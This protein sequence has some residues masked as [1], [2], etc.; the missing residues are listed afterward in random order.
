MASAHNAT[1]GGGKS[2][3]Y[4]TVKKWEKELNCQLEYDVING[5]VHQMI[6][7]D[8]KRWELRINKMAKFSLAWIRPGTKTVEKDSLVKHLSSE[9]HKTAKNLSR[10]SELGAE[11]YM[12]RVIENTPIGR[13]LKKMHE[14][15]KKSLEIKFNT[16]YYLAKKERPYSDYNDLLTLQIKNNIQGIKSH[17]NND[18]TAATFT[19]YI[20]KVMKESLTADL[21]KSRYYACLNDGS[22]D[23]AVIEQEMVYVLF[24]H[25]GTPMVKYLSIESVKSADAEGVKESIEDAFNRIG[26]TRFSSRLTGLNADGASVN[27][28]I[29]RGLGAI[30]KKTAPWLEVIHCFNHRVELAIKDAFDHTEF[31]KIDEMLLKLHYLYKKSPKRLRE[32]QIFS[33][34]M[35]RAVPRPSKA[36][37]TRWIDHKFKAMET[38]LENYGVFMAHIESLSHTDSQVLKRAELEGF[39]KKWQHASYPVHMAIYLDV[40]SPIRRLSLAFQQEKHDPVKAVRRIQDF[41]WTMAKLKLL[42]DNSLESDN[43]K[44]TH[45]N[46][47]RSQIEVKEDGKRYYQNVKLK[48]FNST[49]KAVPGYY[50]DC[51]IRITDS[52][53]GRF[54]NLTES[55]VFK[56]LTSLLDV[57]IW[58][59]ENLT[60]FGD[61][62]INELLQHFRLVLTENGCDIYEA[63]NEWDVLKNTAYQIQINNPKASYLDT[64]KKLFC[65][66]GLRKECENI[67]HLIEILLITP[68]TNAKVERVFSRMARVKTDWRNRLSRDR[69]DNLM[70]IGEEG[71]SLSEY[72]PTE[73]ISSW[74]NAKVRRLTSSSHKYPE[75]RKKSNTKEIIDIT[76][77]TM[78]DLENDYSSDEG[79]EDLW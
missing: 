41:T 15:D 25:E 48:N 32:L 44:L 49:R 73:A 62:Q 38:I 58:P 42:I 76:S 21:A 4:K 27:M 18:R 20:G 1:G 3:G 37:G 75:K 54:H 63:Q 78:S 66:E 29:H 77:V 33:E 74:Y 5:K 64:W 12:E 60:S 68:F 40:L 55:P 53:E 72:S 65:N 36:N 2:S 13:G 56:H 9:Q 11:V 23:S 43:N 69:L 51:I 30:L 71:P 59:K 35:D 7:K 31:G 50:N 70:R 67:L 45:Y 24:L 19:D 52:M 22:T 17:Y 61:S 79:E 10:S 47:L 39:A 26:I 6:C 46:R 14:K 28:G 34:A 16:A 8:C 57:A